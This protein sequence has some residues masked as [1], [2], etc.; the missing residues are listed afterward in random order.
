MSY[1]ERIYEGFSEILAYGVG[2]WLVYDWERFFIVGRMKV[3][4]FYGVYG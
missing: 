2:C 1:S 3:V 4:L